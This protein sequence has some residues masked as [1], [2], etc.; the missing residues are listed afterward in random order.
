[1]YNYSYFAW[2]TCC[3]YGVVDCEVGKVDA[4]NEYKRTRVRVA[5]SAIAEVTLKT[6]IV[7]IG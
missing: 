4:T 6:S 3:K 2:R 7:S 5:E 1:M